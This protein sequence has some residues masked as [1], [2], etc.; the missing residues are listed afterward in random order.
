MAYVSTS[1]KMEGQKNIS[2]HE[3]KHGTLILNLP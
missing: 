3:F 1:D 2:R